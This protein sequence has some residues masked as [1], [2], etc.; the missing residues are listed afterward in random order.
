MIHDE[1]E[2]WFCLL[3]YCYMTFSLEMDSKS[4]PG[5]T[6]YQCHGRVRTETLVPHSHQHI[7]RG[8]KR[9]TFLQMNAVY[10]RPY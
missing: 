10:L 5:Q 3:E 8:L 1:M 2:T 4:D 7:F 6:T 9:L